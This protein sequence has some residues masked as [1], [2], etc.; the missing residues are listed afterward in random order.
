MLSETGFG[1]F[2]VYL[3]RFGGR[4]ENRVNPV[5]GLDTVLVW[6]TYV[7]LSFSRD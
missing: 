6:F 5:R 7:I 2:R 3:L 4:G 1:E